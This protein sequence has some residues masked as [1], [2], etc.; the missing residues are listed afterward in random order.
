MWR[1]ESGQSL[2]EVIIAIAVVAVALTALVSLGTNALGNA[3]FSE[4]QSTGASLTQEALEWV[5]E[6]RDLNWDDFV[7]DIDVNGETWCLENLSFNSPGECGSND[8][9]AD[10]FT[11]EV[12]LN[13][14]DPNIPQV[15]EVEV[16]TSW[17]ESGNQ[18]SSKANTVLTDWR[19]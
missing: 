13:T 15:V 17:I 12:T 18:K 4:N 19:R 7:R 9:I 2:F 8:L 14:D 3:Q 6:Q 10:R 1:S 16:T 11:R 5:R